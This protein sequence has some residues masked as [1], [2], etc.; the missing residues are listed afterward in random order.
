MGQNTIDVTE[1]SFAADVEQQKGLVLVDFWATWCGPCQIIAPVLDQLA[2]DYAGKVRV[3]KLD[4]DAHQR[5]AAR[6]NIRSIPALLFFKD[7]K[8]V[9]TVI[10]AVPKP[11]IESKIQ[12][13]LAA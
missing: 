2:K 10:G 13:H 4:V 8:H 11:A 7:G 9:D 3:T 6:F 1:S 5:V 12:H